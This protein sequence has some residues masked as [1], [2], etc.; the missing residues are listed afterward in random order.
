MFGGVPLKK[1]F[2]PFSGPALNDD[3]SRPYP[4]WYYPDNTFSTHTANNIQKYLNAIDRFGR[5]FENTVLQ[6]E[7]W[8][9]GSGSEEIELLPK[10]AASNNDEQAEILNFITNMKYAGRPDYPEVLFLM[11]DEGV[12]TRLLEWNTDAFTALYRA[13][14]SNIAQGEP[15]N[16]AV[17]LLNPSALN[18][19]LGLGDRRGV[20]AFSD[21]GADA[22]FGRAGGAVASSRPFAVYGPPRGKRASAFTVFPAV[23]VTAL[24]NMPDSADYL[25]EIIIPGGARFSILKQLSRYGIA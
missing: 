22:L 17:W 10:S 18:R 14:N 2:Y 8:F 16:S 3:P 13:I 20:P 19:S 9:L 11:Y 23:N 21:S 1:N 6:T 4:K 5:R 24:E 7:I 15:S 25:S 12:P